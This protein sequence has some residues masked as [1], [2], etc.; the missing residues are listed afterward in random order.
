MSAYCH[1]S[2]KTPVGL[3]YAEKMAEVGVLRSNS[4]NSIP[5]AV[6]SNSRLAA[7][8]L[9]FSDFTIPALEPVAIQSTRSS[10]HDWRQTLKTQR[11]RS[12]TAFKAD[13]MPY[14][15]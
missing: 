4:R 8:V 5:F 3:L 13:R 10:S 14:G 9:K 12:T 11:S 1:G 6:Q 15:Q 2:K 7:V